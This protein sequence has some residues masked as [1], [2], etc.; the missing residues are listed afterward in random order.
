MVPI[1]AQRMFQN[2]LLA[3][4]H[5]TFH[6]TPLTRQVILLLTFKLGLSWGRDDVNNLCL[7]HKLV[8]LTLAPMYGSLLGENPIFPQYL[9]NILKS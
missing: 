1:K 4:Y 8:P 7:A 5:G 3:E 9:Q 2:I 6:D